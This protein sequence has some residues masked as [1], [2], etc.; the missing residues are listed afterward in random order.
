VYVSHNP[1]QVLK[2]CK[3]GIVLKDGGVL[4]DGDAMGAIEALG[5]RLDF[6]DDDDDSA[7]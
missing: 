2:M 5:Y 3:R 7:A 1:K 4:F 6:D